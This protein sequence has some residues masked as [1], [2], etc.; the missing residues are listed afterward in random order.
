MFD[1]DLDV[2]KF[3]I[4][5]IQDTK[6]ATAELFWVHLLKLAQEKKLKLALY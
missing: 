3:H 4:F 2:K 6:N 5:D 1:M